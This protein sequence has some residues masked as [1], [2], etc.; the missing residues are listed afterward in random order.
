MRGIGGSVVEH[1]KFQHPKGAAATR[2]NVLQKLAYLAVIFGLLPLVIVM[3][4]AMS[5]WLDSVVPGW[6]DIVGGRQ[7]ARTLHFMAAW[8]LVLFFLVHIFEVIISGLVNQIRSM[9]T[10]RYKVEAEHAKPL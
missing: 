10:G 6:V 3:G 4:W 2:Y 9:V 8:G 7:S 5:P 1:L